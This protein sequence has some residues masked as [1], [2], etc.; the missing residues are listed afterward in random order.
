MLTKSILSQ[1]YSRTNKLVNNVP[2]II[3]F[4]RCS[5]FVC[6]L[7]LSEEARIK[8]V[9]TTF[10]RAHKAQPS[11]NDAIYLHFK[12]KNDCTPHLFIHFQQHF[13]WS[14]LSAL[15]GQCNNI[16]NNF[17]KAKRSCH[18]SSNARSTPK[19]NKL[20][21]CGTHF[22]AFNLIEAELGWKGKKW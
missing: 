13:C 10:F 15:F 19:A 6:L 12:S 16:Q 4:T 17:F 9:T 7:S 20:W 22:S 5:F 1:K 2:T 3:Y 14:F 18:Y 21:Y 11:R 8:E